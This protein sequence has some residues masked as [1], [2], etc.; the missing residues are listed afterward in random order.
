M[1][2]TYR[3]YDQTECHTLQLGIFQ[4]LDKEPKAPRGHISLYRVL[5][6]SSRPID[7]WLI[8]HN[9]KCLHN[10]RDFSST[11]LSY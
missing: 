4:K 6:T 7:L 9:K 10:T 8:C 2:S 1:Y 3:L 5:S 11:S